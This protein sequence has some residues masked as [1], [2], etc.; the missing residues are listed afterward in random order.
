M[1]RSDVAFV[2]VDVETTGLTGEARGGLRAGGLLLE[3]G[4]LLVDA[5]LTP[6]L[7][8]STLIRQTPW[9]PGSRE[10][11]HPRV[12]SMHD[13]SGLWAA[14]MDG[15]TPSMPAGDAEREALAWL[16][17]YGLE[18]GTMPMGGSSVHFDRAWLAV[19]MPALH[20][21]FTHRNADVSAVRE[22]A[23]A[24]NGGP[25]DT[26]LTPRGVHRVL[27]DMLDTLDLL[28]WQRDHLFRAAP[29]PLTGGVRV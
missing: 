7:D 26:G 14:H 17:S 3:V 11:C 19:H 22:I 8:W 29:S 1:P 12:R 10:M 24:L 25:I 5:D 6:I 4:L 21:W 15:E 23:A 16:A 13:K 20:D 27:P 9:V 28:R 18:P 2:L